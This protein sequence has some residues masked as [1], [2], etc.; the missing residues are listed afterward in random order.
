MSVFSFGKIV[1][2]VA[3]KNWFIKIILFPFILTRGLLALA[4]FL[5]QYF[6]PHNLPQNSEIINQGWLFSSH[7]LIDMW[8]RWDSGWYLSVIRLGYSMGENVYVSS[9]LAFFPVFPYLVKIIGWL[10][11]LG[12]VNDEIFVL[13]GVIL[14][15]L[16]LIASLVIIY[17][18]TMLFFKNKTIAGNAVWLL[19]IFPTSFF[20]SSFYS[21]STFLFF[22]ILSFWAAYKRKWFIACMM[23]S[24][25][26]ATRP[27][28]IMIGLPLLLE[29]LSSKDWKLKQIDASILWFLLIPVGATIFFWH[30]YEK[31]GD[32]LAA[33]KVQSAWGKKPTN[34]FSTFL[35]PTG[36][37]PFITQ[38][39]QL[40]IISVFVTS[41]LMLRKSIKKFLPLVV[42]AVL[43]ITPL[44]FG[45]TIVSASRFIV[46]I[47][48]LF[49]Y[50]AF[51]LKK[52]E[53]LSFY[54]K[55]VLMALQI[56]LFAMFSQ[57]YWVG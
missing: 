45:G 54:V 16:L 20:L 51:L 43:S 33:V 49:M 28:G 40:S 53:K 8:A 5:I 3:K 34:P 23:A 6:L 36:Y 17:H 11:P 32:F 56:I 10:F 55:V 31:T 30:L 12:V 48:P 41:F 13:I 2:M 7:R 50:W 46:V 4:G 24:I 37:W 35:F 38:L 14:S 57:F 26:G 52:S 1:T 25:L 22:S 42:Y 15:N 27:L 39:D 47:F 9:N 29:Y 19:L 21:E 44:L 18:L